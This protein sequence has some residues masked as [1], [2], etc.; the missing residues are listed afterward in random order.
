MRMGISV[1]PRHLKD[2]ARWRQIKAEEVLEPRWPWWAFCIF[3]VFAA[4]VLYYRK[5]STCG[6][7]SIDG[8]TY[9]PKTLEGFSLGR[10]MTRFGVVFLWWGWILLSCCLLGSAL[11]RWIQVPFSNRGESIVFG[12]G[13]GL[14]SCA[15]IVFVLGV[16]HLWSSRSMILILCILSACGLFG[17]LLNRGGAPEAALPEDHPIHRPWS[18]LD[19]VLIA[20]LAAMT[21]LNFLG[22]LSPPTFYDELV[23]HL[24]LPKAYAIA[25]GIFPTPHNLYS[26]F[27]FL[28]EMLYGLSLLLSNEYA[29]KLLH[30][31][32][33]IGILMGLVSFSL[34]YFDRRVGLLAAL[35]FETTPMVS[36]E[37][38]TAM[39]ELSWGFFTFLAMYALL[40]AARTPQGAGHRRWVRLSAV[41]TGW[42]L[43]IKYPTILYWF[44]A[45]VFWL[46]WSDFRYQKQGWKATA[47]ETGEFAAIALLLWVPWLAKNWIFYRNPWH[48]LLSTMFPNA[49]L[50]N[51]DFAGLMQDASS[52]ALGQLL[53]PAELLN[54][55]LSP[56]RAAMNCASPLTYLSPAF[57]LLAP[58]T[59]FFRPSV[60]TFRG[61]LF[62]AL[63]WWFT[64]AISTDMT[65]FL[66]PA[67]PP[68]CLLIALAVLWGR[69]PRFIKFLL[70]ALVFFWIVANA[71]QNFEYYAVLG[72]WRT[73]TGPMSAKEFLSH[74]QGLYPSPYFPAMD[75][76][77]HH[78]PESG[79]VLFIGET[80]SY[81]SE[82]PA[83]VASIFDEQPIVTALK[84]SRNEDDLY[85]VLRRQGVTHIFINEI[86]T[87]RARNYRRF[88]LGPVDLETWHRFF[89]KYLREVFQ[90]V[91]R[92]PADQR[93]VYVYEITAAPRSSPN[94]G[95]SADPFLRVL[96]GP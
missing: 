73:V 5:T 63:G 38:W 27:P 51:V 47:L 66:I 67:L 69:M 42:S 34:R 68:L 40:N 88:P 55:V 36:H 50:G 6:L 12:G 96:Q 90:D 22:A 61:L 65:R 23:Y 11:L 92:E 75:F 1:K 30:F 45:A 89:G 95:N 84:K 26:G 10:F 48:P 46:A 29:A 8:F 41:C 57:F 87:L 71:D 19:G 31:S 78:V 15:S 44:P 56:W 52:H 59:I 64:C 80:R 77:N 54:L 18:L 82:R 94:A 32:L 16:T 3:L 28:T 37:S 86:E 13:I 4:G 60:R 53:H 7:F 79:K 14:G 17:E 85:G 9:F 72:G 21:M 83:E 33:S 24:A 49:A 70:Q 91:H 35:L 74:H 81:Y 2:S 62:M 20:G 25:H 43:G 39:I 76:V 58:L 93:V